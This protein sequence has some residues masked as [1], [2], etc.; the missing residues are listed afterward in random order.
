MVPQRQCSAVPNR[1]R[2]KQKAAYGVNQNSLSANQSC[3]QQQHSTQLRSFAVLVSHCQ[4]RHRSCTMLS[5]TV[6][7]QV[8]CTIPQQ[9][10]STNYRL[11][12]KVLV[13]NEPPGSMRHHTCTTSS[14]TLG[15]RIDSARSRCSPVQHIS[16]VDIVYIWQRQL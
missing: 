3:R 13:S 5:K 4:R 11:D 2:R 12:V 15:A 16:A 9:A 6:P 8:R 7:Q 14:C 1:S 10:H